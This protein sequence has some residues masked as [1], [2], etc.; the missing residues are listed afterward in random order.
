[1]KARCLFNKTELLGLIQ[2]NYISSYCEK[3]Q[4]LSYPK[5]IVSIKLLLPRLLTWYDKM[6]DNVNRNEHVIVKRPTSKRMKF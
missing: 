6:K 3:L 5:D 2:P 4:K 1:M